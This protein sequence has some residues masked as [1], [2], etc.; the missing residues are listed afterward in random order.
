MSSLLAYLQR[1]SF[2]LDQL[3]TI[4]ILRRL[5]EEVT[6]LR[7][8]AFFPFE[9]AQGVTLLLRPGGLVYDGFAC[10]AVSRAR[11]ELWRALRVARETPSRWDF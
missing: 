2:P 11:A 8:A 7:D 6:R 3:S 10:P 9:L 4:R 5:A 1:T